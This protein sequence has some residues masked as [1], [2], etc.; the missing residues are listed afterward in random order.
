M[1]EIEDTEDGEE[2]CIGDSFAA[3]DAEGIWVNDLLA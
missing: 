1:V 3:H 2:V